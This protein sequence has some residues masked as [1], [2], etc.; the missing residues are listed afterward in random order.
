[1][2]DEEYVNI[3]LEQYK[4]MVSSSEK[5]TEARQKTNGFFLTLI[6][7]LITL[8]V[9]VGKEFSF[10][11]NSLWIMF[12]VSLLSLFMSIFWW[13]TVH[14]YSLLNK[15][16]FV[17]IYELEEKLKSSLFEREWEILKTGVRYKEASYIEK[18]LVCVVIGA[19]SLLTIIELGFIIFPQIQCTCC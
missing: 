16:K 14:S 5:V 19:T 2:S 1:M 18:V 15:G 11:T 8:S 10:S 6:T 13:Y 17:L 7:S 9:I 12:T 3:L 4:I